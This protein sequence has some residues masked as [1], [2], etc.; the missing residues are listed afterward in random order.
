LLFGE[1]TISENVNF[2]GK[3]YVLSANH[4][5]ITYYKNSYKFKGNE[6][7]SLRIIW[8]DNIVCTYLTKTQPDTFVICTIGNER[9]EEHKLEKFQ[10]K[11]EKRRTLSLEGLD[12]D[13]KTKPKDF[14]RVKEYCIQMSSSEAANSW[15]DGINARLKTLGQIDPMASL[16]FISK[17]EK[18]IKKNIETIFTASQISQTFIVF[19]KIEEIEE[20]LN[21]IDL[22]KF[23]CIIS[24]GTVELFIKVYEVAKEKKISPDTFFDFIPTTSKVDVS[25][26]SIKSVDPVFISANF[27]RGFLRTFKDI[28]KVVNKT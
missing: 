28:K 15:V 26:L 6:D 16:I 18:R 2:L 11:H 10:E 17:T 20:K 9:I 4:N 25:F 3:S 27:V 1:I 19:N 24:V 7:V 21:E 22:E 12:I 14:Y 23:Q 5:G 13:T 8:W